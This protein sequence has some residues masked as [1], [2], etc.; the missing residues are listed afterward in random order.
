MSPPS[1]PLPSPFIVALPPLPGVISSVALPGSDGTNS[2]T[3]FAAVPPRRY[4]ITCCIDVLLTSNTSALP[5]G[6]SDG[7]FV[8]IHSTQSGNNPGEELYR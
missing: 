7:G 1:S 4:L 6:I 2:D 5:H 3:T 8:I